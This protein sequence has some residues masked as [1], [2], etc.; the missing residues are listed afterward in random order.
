MMKNLLVL[1]S[2][3]AL[4][5]FAGCSS[6]KKA[7]KKVNKQ[8]VKTVAKTTASAVTTVSTASA[9]TVSAVT[10][11]AVTTAASVTASAVTTEEAVD[12]TT[13]AGVLAKIENEYI[14]E[15]DVENEFEN[16][17]EQ[18]KPYYSTEDGKKK[19]LENL[20][21]Q[22]ILKIVAIKDGIEKDK[23]YIKEISKLN[24]RV[25]ANYAVKRNILDKVKATDS[26]IE[27]KY[28]EVK[29][30][31]RT[32]EEVKASH[33]LLMFKQD[34][35]EEDKKALLE[36]AEGL[37]KEALEGKDFAEIAKANSDDGSAANGGN[38]GWF[39]KGMMVK[40]FED[41][42]F[43]GEAGKVYPKVVETQFGYHIIKVEEKKPA[44][45]KSLEEIKDKLSEEILNT[46]RS[47][48]FYKWMDE[49]KKQYLK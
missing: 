6:T 8:P 31:Y 38:L 49:L 9:V 1:I 15:E 11:S 7:D 4:I 2:I 34:M 44:S 21:N 19:I 43:E 27:A 42:C 46:K 32:G 17:P 28:N 14:T 12:V 39:A 30:Q 37:L 33:V 40:P 3:A 25:L 26:E 16:L 13:V 35:K 10:T 45:Y 36:K 47:D 29:E 23:E 41:A 22:K 20:I 18:Y 5:S 24:E 48:A